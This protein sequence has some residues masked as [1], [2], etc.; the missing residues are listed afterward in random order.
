MNAFM[1]LLL[2]WSVAESIPILRRQGRVAPAH[3]T[4]HD[5]VP[6]SVAACQ[7]M[8]RVANREDNINAGGRPVVRPWSVTWG[9]SFP[10]RSLA[11]PSLCQNTSSLLVAVRDGTRT[12]PVTATFP[13]DD[14]VEPRPTSSSLQREVVPSVFHPQGCGVPSFTPQRLCSALADYSDVLLIGDSLMR[15]VRQA[16]M[17]VSSGDW[18]HG[19]WPVDSTNGAKAQD[20]SDCRCDG[21]FSEVAYCRFDLGSFQ[22]EGCAPSLINFITWKLN[23]PVTDNAALLS[24]HHGLQN[25]DLCGGK[26]K[27]LVVIQGGVHG[28]Y[29]TAKMETAELDPIFAQLDA[30][31]ASCPVPR[32][33][34]LTI[35]YMAA[36]AQSRRLDGPYP[37]QTREKVAAFNEEIETYLRTKRPDVLVLNFWN[38][39][40]DA[41]T[42]DGF[43]YLTDVNV[44]KVYTLLRLVELEAR[45]TK[46]IAPQ[47]AKTMEVQEKLQSANAVMADTSRQAATQ[48]TPIVPEQPDP[49]SNVPWCRDRRIEYNV[50]V[51]KSWGSLPPLD[52]TKWAGF[53]CDQLGY[54]GQLDPSMVH[55][56]HVNCFLC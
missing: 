29:D 1:G 53:L 56:P 55:V 6:L 18:E 36:D 17:M 26:G 25:H 8:N 4:T 13:E 3:A 30:V 41:P 32:P 7:T 45:T 27:K 15:H 23:A 40:R 20:R 33:D 48:T 42:S 54:D 31:V 16:L 39:T 24:Q 44:A 28:R 14:S 9:E 49:A 47:Q 10:L 35:V 11:N 34:L 46:E 2:L 22:H 12:W 51:G 5:M 50:V 38:M 37:V 19:A 52:R 43:H 21:S